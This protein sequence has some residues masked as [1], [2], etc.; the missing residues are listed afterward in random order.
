MDLCQPIED[1]LNG[2]VST[3]I[4]RFRQADRDRLEADHGTPITAP[5]TAHREEGN[6][7]T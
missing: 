1:F 6:P 3:E 5:V 2:P 7:T 4:L